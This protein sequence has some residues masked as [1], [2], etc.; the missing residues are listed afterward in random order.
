M[1][2]LAIATGL[3]L[4]LGCAHVA[5]VANAC[6]P[7]P[8]D[9][10]T[11]LTDLQH[12]TWQ[13]DLEALLLAKGPCIARAAVQEVIDALGGSQSLEMVGTL[14]SADIVS[15]GKAWIAAHP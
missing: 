9:V 2:L 7:G 5:A 1:K 4:W 11:A 3:M 14:S 13:T 15:R 10:D 12:D 6:K 8:A